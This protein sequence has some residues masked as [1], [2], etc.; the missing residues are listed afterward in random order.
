MSSGNF[1]CRLADAVTE[2]TISRD[3]IKYRLQKAILNHLLLAN[4]PECDEFPIYFRNNLKDIISKVTAKNRN[5]NDAIR[6]TLE[7]KHG[8]TLSLIA[9]SILQLHREYE[10]YLSSGFIPS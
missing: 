8:K 3:T 4:V 2:L 10:E 6:A 9:L 7:G 5:G 1:K